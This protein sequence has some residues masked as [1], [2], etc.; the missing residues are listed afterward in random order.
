MISIQ[1]L[2]AKRTI[3]LPALNFKLT[4]RHGW[5]AALALPLVIGP[6]WC[7]AWYES[8]VSHWLGTLSG[9]VLLA[10]LITCA[11]TDVRSHR[12]YNW[13]TYSAFL[14]ALAINIATSSMSSGESVLNQAYQRATILGPQ[15]LG[16]VGIAQCLVGAGLCFLITL[17]GYHL[18]ARGAGDVKLATVIGA[19][20]GVHYGVFAVGYSYI[21]AAIAI[22]IW[23]AWVHG[24]FAL[25]IA[26]GRSLGLAW[27]PKWW[28]F[29]PRP[30]DS[31]IL[32]KPVPL[33]P[34]FAIGTLLV[35]LEIVPV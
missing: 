9:L 18:S 8:P 16:G 27:R 32:L 5:A 2:T 13:A 34:Y 15:M 35:V 17:F 14:W 30:Q 24:P 22:I 20:L 33:G 10:V 31:R 21:V 6:V 12:I 29:P 25:V 19:L 11:I 3:G 26:M 4:K 23:S 7:L 1:S 28:P